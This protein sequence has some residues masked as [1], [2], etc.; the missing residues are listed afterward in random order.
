ML[1]E[2][3]VRCKEN[4]QNTHRVGDRCGVSSNG[5]SQLLVVR[6]TGDGVLGACPHQFGCLGVKFQPA[7]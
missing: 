3:E 6:K 7:C 2:C 5:Q 1:L 4:G